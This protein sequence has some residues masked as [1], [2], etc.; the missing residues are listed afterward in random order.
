[1][2]ENVKPV[3]K[4]GFNL[5]NALRVA[6]K[7]PGVKIDRTAFLKKELNKL[8]DDSVVEK[9]IETNP[10]QA[11]ISKKIISNM[12][13]SSIT[14]ETTKVS[15][16]SAAS[17]IPGGFAMAATIPADM[18]QY[19]AHILRILQKLA[20]L[21]GWQEFSFDDDDQS[22]LD[23]E[24][25][26]QL[27]LFIGVMFGV[28]AAKAAVVKIANALAANV[29]KALMKKALTKGVIFPIVKKIAALLGIKM[30]KEVFAKGVGKII[31]VIGAVVSGGVTLAGFVPMARHLRD[32]LAGLPLADPET[33]K[34]RKDEGGVVDLDFS[35]I[36]TEEIDAEISELY[37]EE[38]NK[39][40]KND[41]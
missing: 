7:M 8:C 37:D 27:I 26:N 4:E 29:P 25:M 30:T 17:G 20:Y 3:K 38:E 24:T 28:D 19:L 11:G 35:D 10:A 9:A 16:L 39:A 12:A 41:I 5:E 1:M 21:Y 13:K 18:V 15:L 2:A 31:P 40:V 22:V 34:N 23:E 33:Y 6:I 14:F 36:S 32:Y